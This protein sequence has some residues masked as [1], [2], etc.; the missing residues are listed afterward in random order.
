M[1]TDKI[2][3]LKGRHAA[4]IAENRKLLDLAQQENRRLSGDEETTYEN[5]DGDIGSLYKEIRRW[6]NQLS[7]ELHVNH[8]PNSPFKPAPEPD[9]SPKNRRATKE[10]HDLFFN[11]YCRRNKE[12]LGPNVFNALEVGTDSEGGYLVPD[13]WATTL[14]RELPEMVAM[15]RYARVIQTRGDR[16]L[17]VQT[18]RGAFT[19]TAEEGSFSTNDP[20]YN[21]I[22]VSAHKV[23]GII[24]VSD[25][26]VQDNQYDL[27]GHLRMDANEEFSDKEEDAF[28]SGDNTGKPEGIFAATTIAGVSI[29]GT[30]GAVSATPVVTTDNIIDTYHGLPRKYRSRAAWF[31]S[32]GHVKIIRKLKDTNDQY[33]WQPGLVAGVTDR[34]L[35]SPVE[36]SDSAPVPATASRGICFGDW[37]YYTIVDR[38]DMELKRLDEL[39]AAT[40][41]I[42]FRFA[43]RVDGHMTM[44]NAM[45]FYAHGAAT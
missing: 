43:R 9:A 26:L 14:I 36:I 10:Y 30:T 28:M 5:R 19:W 29:T 32:D 40:G 27:A 3:E 12:H 7:Q 22:V 31:M 8:T 11:Q 33:L 34:L 1:T 44:A 16:N 15:R 6:E 18:S 37:S 21:N 4:L 45:T 41:Q 2:N 38:L 20:A 17:P 23:G 13:E 42:G 25:E 39:Y 24:V 35:G